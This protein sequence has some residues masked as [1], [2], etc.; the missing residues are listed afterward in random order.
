MSNECL[1]PNKH[2]EISPIVKSNILASKFNSYG[3][4]INPLQPHVAYLY[5]LNA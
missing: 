1:L 3:I 5:P 2:F 4:H